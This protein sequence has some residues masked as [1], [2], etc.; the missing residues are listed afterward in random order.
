MNRLLVLLAVLIPTVSSYAQVIKSGTM[1]YKGGD[2]Y[3]ATV[4]EDGTILMDSMS[5]GQEMQFKMVPDGDKKNAYVVAQGPSEYADMPFP[6]GYKIRYRHQDGMK[7]LCVYNLDGNLQ[8]TFNWTPD[9]SRHNNIWTWIPQLKGVYTLQPDG[10]QITINDMTVN[11]EGMDGEY[12]VQTFNDIA[13]GVVKISHQWVN[14]YFEMVPTLNGFKVYQG[15]FDEYGMFQRSGEPYSLVESDPWKGRFEFA[16][17]LLLNTGILG[18]YKR[19][20]LRIMRNEI[21]ARHGYVFQSK[22]LKEYFESQ[23]W[24]KPAESDSGIALSF[25]EQLNVEMIKT[26]EADP[27]HDEY[28]WEE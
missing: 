7:V 12:E 14:G 17:T 10:Y 6:E 1:W 23:P 3:T 19:S 24:Y 9:E 25:I 4:Q 28:V 26:A 8:T 22:D 15:S 20:T 2:N 5:E 27:D 11:V 16:S 13:N 21:L 18:K